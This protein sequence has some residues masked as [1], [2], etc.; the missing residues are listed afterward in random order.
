MLHV[1][2]LP[3]HSVDFPR[4]FRLY[5]VPPRW[6]VV[7]RAS[8]MGMSS[9]RRLLDCECEVAS[10]GGRAP[11][12]HLQSHDS[13]LTRGPSALTRQSGSPIFIA[14]PGEPLG[15]CR[16]SALK[17]SVKAVVEAIMWAISS[18]GKSG[19]LGDST[20]P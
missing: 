18:R 15:F 13:L 7:L 6:C 16:Y 10:S 11:E 9:P 3:F 1:N 2:K 14:G 12:L 20:C 5:I 8:S 4:H 17:R 19:C